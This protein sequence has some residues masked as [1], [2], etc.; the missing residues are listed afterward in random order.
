MI[1]NGSEKMQE[2][3]YDE[4]VKLIGKPRII[5]VVKEYEK[6]FLMKRLNIM[7]PE[8]DLEFDDSLLIS[9]NEITIDELVP[10]DIQVLGY[11]AETKRLPFAIDQNLMPAELGNPDGG[12]IA[13]LI[14]VKNTSGEEL[15]NIL[16]RKA[17]DE[18]NLID[19]TT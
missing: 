16:G 13:F 5:S 10:N 6:L 11:T 12:D 1:K 9:N 18:Y 19:Y 7:Y 17:L 15:R 8:M 4:L 3:E 2:N 14:S